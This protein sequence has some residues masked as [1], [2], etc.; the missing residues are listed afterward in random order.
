MYVVMCIWKWFQLLPLTWSVAKS[1]SWLWWS[2]K[3][4]NPGRQPS[5]WTI[6]ARFWGSEARSR[7]WVTTDSASITWSWNWQTRTSRTYCLLLLSSGF[8]LKFMNY[9]QQQTYNRIIKTKT[10]LLPSLKFKIVP[11]KI[12]V[13]N[14][15]IKK[16]VSLHCSQR[17]RHVNAS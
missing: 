3:R 5:S 4:T 12:K 6:T 2:R 14:I 8:G 11:A 17:K 7:S 15:S 10:V 16:V 9:W 1:T 13:R